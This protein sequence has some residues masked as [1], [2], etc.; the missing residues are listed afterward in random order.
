MYLSC[1]LTNADLSI[2]ED[3]DYYKEKMDIVHKN[4]VTLGKGIEFNNVTLHIRDTALLAPQGKR[5]LAELG[6]MY[7]EKYK[8]V[9]LPVKYKGQMELLLKD[10]PK[11]F[12]DYAIQDSIISLKHANEMEKF[13]MGLGKIGVPITL[14]SLGKQYVLKRWEEESY[15][16]QVSSLYLVGDTHKV[17]T[18][19]GLDKWKNVG[20]ILGHFIGN[21]KGGRNESYMYGCDLEK[22]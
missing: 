10:D 17:Y 12:E 2:L 13:N 16:Y 9:D 19:Q 15:S 21:Y 4:F 7:G 20:L 18:P 6:K 1:H 14:S 5:A 8:K 3:F 22:H 11:L